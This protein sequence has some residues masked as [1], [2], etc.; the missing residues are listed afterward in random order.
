MAV[1]NSQK[2]DST[3]KTSASREE[4]IAHYVG[5]RERLRTRFLLDGGKSMPDYELLE[6]L[7]MFAIPRRDVKEKAKQLLKNFGSFA[8]VLN[9][10]QKD[11][12]AQHLSL[13]AVAV[14]KAVSA[15]AVRLTLDRLTSNSKTIIGSFDDLISYARAAMGGL[16][17][18]E[19][20]ILF[21]DKHLH[22][23]KDEI[24]QRGTINHVAIHPR[25]VVKA[26]LENKAASVVLFHNHPGGKA[27]PSKDDLTMTTTLTDAL[28]SV[29]IQVYDH[30]I[31]T[32]DNYF[33]FAA[34]GLL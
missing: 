9:A 34:N 2:S 30:I 28:N 16:D 32:Q 4:A 21:L 29:E 26:A 33:S 24:M 5:H 14:L 15:A 6:L 27:S 13:T 18:E 22:V 12:L 11:L 31:I 19:F 8:G 1:K 10:S 3:Q 20:R 25:E 23:I 17:V 7:L